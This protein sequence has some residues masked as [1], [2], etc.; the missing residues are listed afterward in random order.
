MPLSTAFGAK[1]CLVGSTLSGTASIL[2]RL[3]T[4]P[5]VQFTKKILA[6]RISNS[7][8]SA[9]NYEIILICIC[10]RQN[11]YTTPFTDFF[12]FVTHGGE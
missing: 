2:L 12:P 7:A 9:K 3:V 1:I 5:Q 11:M 10:S 4:E 8:I 6:D